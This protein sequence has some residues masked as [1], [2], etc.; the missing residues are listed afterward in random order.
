MNKVKSPIVAIVISLVVCIAVIVAIYSIVKPVSVVEAKAAI[1]AGT[2]LTQDLIEVKTVPSGGLPADYYSN[3]A[4]VIGKTVA[5]S[6]AAGD[7][8]TTTILSET[9]SAGVPSELEPGHVAIAIHVD[10]ASA[11]AGILRSGQTVTIIGLLSPDVLQNSSVSGS[12]ETG[13][14]VIS[15]N[16][17]EVTTA[18][19]TT[20][21]NPTPT[22]EPTKIV[23]PLARI[24]I[25]GIRILMVPQDFQYQE[26]PANA[27]QQTLFANQQA[28]SNDSS[29]IVLDV[30]NTAVEITPG[31]KVNPAT[32]IAALDKYGSIYLALESS[33]AVEATPGGSANLTINLAEL[34]K[35][36]NE[37]TGLEP[38]PTTQ[39]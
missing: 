13:Q 8:I 37:S 6:R 34:Y 27:D 5:V 30:P 36:I 7:Y 21:S 12:F 29:V 33:A 22:P 32:L 18:D 38:T 2:V 10:R 9:A 31:Y 24:T 14:T 28:T 20:S 23:G 15:A 1:S 17:Q 26:V 4:D 25:T 35:I 19:L 16:S 3:I 11:V 39:K